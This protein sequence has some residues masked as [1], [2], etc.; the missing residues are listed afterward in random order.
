M[1][2]CKKPGSEKPVS[3]LDVKRGDELVCEILDDAEMRLEEKYFELATHINLQTE[4]IGLQVHFIGCLERQIADQEK[5]M[6]KKNKD[7]SDGKEKV[8]NKI[9]QWSDWTSKEKEDKDKLWNKISILEEAVK[10]AEK[11]NTDNVKATK[12]MI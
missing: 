11:Q 9:N 8:W 1:K 6:Q 4:Q 2:L 12:Q 5:M 7:Y 10:K 3:N